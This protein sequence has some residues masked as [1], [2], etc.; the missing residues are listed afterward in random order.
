[1]K[2]EWNQMEKFIDDNIKCK[3]YFIKGGLLEPVHLNPSECD[4]L[5]KGMSQMLEKC[6][7][8]IAI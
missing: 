2:E 6:A 4:I 1:M 5:V 7:Q 3:R 8:E